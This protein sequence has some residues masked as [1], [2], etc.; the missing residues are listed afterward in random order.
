MAQHV[1][2]LLPKNEDQ[3]L[4]TQHS[5]KQQQ[6]QQQTPSIQKNELQIQWEIMT[7]V[8]TEETKNDKLMSFFSG[9]A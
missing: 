7:Q 4:I 1:K 9:R 3:N 2:Y 8:N 5:Y 6:Q